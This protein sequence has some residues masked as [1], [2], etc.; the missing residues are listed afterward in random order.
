MES[1]TPDPPQRGRTPASEATTRRYGG[2]SDTGE[3]LGFWSAEEFHGVNTAEVEIESSEQC[4]GAGGGAVVGAHH[5]QSVAEEDCETG[6]EWERA[7]VYD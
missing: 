1:P 2:F 5:G 4:E 3:E 6:S 7:W